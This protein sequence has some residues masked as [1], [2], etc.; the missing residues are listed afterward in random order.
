MAIRKDARSCHFAAAGPIESNL[1]T[2]IR[3]A[4]QLGIDR[5]VGTTLAT[6]IST[7][8]PAPQYRPIGSGV[9]GLGMA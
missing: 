1:R 9:P 8:A 7:V 2:A 5:P 3:R 4:D 6:S